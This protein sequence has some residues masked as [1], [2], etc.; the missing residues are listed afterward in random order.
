MKTVYLLRHAHAENA[1]PEG[2][3]DHERPLSKQGEREALALGAWLRDAGISPGIIL[4]S[5]SVRTTQTVFH[6]LGKTDGA[7]FD[8]ALYQ[9]SAAKILRL[10][11]GADD[12]AHS[13]LVVCHNPGV[14]ECADLLGAELG[15]ISPAT[16]VA[17]SADCESWRDFSPDLTQV[18]KVF[19]AETQ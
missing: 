2:G 9:A 19:V 6:A 11:Q 1:P 8:R 13:L 7:V 14:S 4:C 16:L 5:S 10:I 12:K 17:F 15:H 3:G 18:G